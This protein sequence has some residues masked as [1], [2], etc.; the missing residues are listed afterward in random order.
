MMTMTTAFYTH[1]NLFFLFLFFRRKYGGTGLGLSICLQLVQLMAGSINVSSAPGK[2]SNFY[3]TVQVSKLRHQASRSIR[4]DTYEEQRQM[5]KCISQIRVLAISKYAATITMIRHLLPGIYIDGVL[6]IDE[7][8]KLASQN[9]YD[10]IIVGLF[11]NPETTKVPRSWLEDASKINPK[12]LIII[13]NYPAGGMNQKSRWIEPVASQQLECKA[14]RIAVPLRRAKLVRTIAEM[15][16]K[17]IPANYPKAV[18][19]KPASLITDEERAR[20]SNLNILIAEGN[21]VYI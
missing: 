21:S 17:K 9:S 4:S 10:V 13:M 1:K 11:M 12:G 14:V 5:L 15:L 8:Q 18:K 6:H 7:F 19:P 20:Y 2:G 3:F 16:D